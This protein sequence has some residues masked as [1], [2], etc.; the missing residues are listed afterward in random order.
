VSARAG[1]L[2]EVR[3]ICETAERDKRGAV[4]VIARLECGH[5]VLR[6]CPRSSVVRCGVCGSQPVMG[7]RRVDE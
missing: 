6:R 1:R 5:E 7:R 2:V 4:L 3:E